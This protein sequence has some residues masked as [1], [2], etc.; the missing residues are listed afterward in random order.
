M[1]Q[2]SEI[3]MHLLQK[4]GTS[5]GST[6]HD[7]VWHSMSARV[8]SVRKNILRNIIG[9]SW[10]GSALPQLDEDQGPVSI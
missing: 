7:M 4:N 3:L 10:Y 6:G 2:I 5:G 8:H 1:L 9:R